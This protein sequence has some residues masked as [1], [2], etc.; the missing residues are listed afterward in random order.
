LAR[1]RSLEKKKGRASQ[2]ELQ[3]KSST[4][5]KAF[6]TATV[7]LLHF[8]T[9][10]KRG[11]NGSAGHYLGV[12]DDLSVRLKQHYEGKGAKIVRAAVARGITLR[13]ARVWIVPHRDAFIVERRLK[14]QKNCRRHLCPVCSIERNESK[15]LLSEIAITVNYSPAIKRS[16]TSTK[17]SIASARVLLRE[18]DALSYLIGNS[19]DITGFAAASEM[20]IIQAK[21]EFVL[22]AAMV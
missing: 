3:R 15:L 8:N 14:Q 18:A 13:L 9:G 1:A 4:V 2:I 20:T 21:R 22:A 17:A 12:A 7:Y 6:H 11:A 19:N 16:I 5:K 10:L